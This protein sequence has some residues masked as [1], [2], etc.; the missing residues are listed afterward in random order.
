[1]KDL[2]AAAVEIMEAHF[3]FAMLKPKV[4][5]AWQTIKEELAKEELA[6]PSTNK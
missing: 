5:A 6:Q 1:M 3:P 2:V 4:Q